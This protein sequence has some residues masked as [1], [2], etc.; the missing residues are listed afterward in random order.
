M[1]VNPNTLKFPIGS[2]VLYEDPYGNGY[3][4]LID[5]VGVVFGYF[6]SMIEVRFP[7][8]DDVM[9]CYDYELA[10]VTDNDKV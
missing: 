4:D 9:C 3:T 2:T 8:E 10:V 5:P 6:G 7:Y 1:A